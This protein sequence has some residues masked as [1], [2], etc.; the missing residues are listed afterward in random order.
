[1]EDLS[2]YVTVKECDSEALSLAYI[3]YKYDEDDNNVFYLAPQTCTE[4]ITMSKTDETKTKEL[5]VEKI[6]E[7][8]SKVK[9]HEFSMKHVKDISKINIYIRNAKNYIATDGRIGFATNMLVSEDNF[10]KYNLKNVCEELKFDV[11]FDDSVKDVILYRKNNI[12]QPGLV[13]FIHEDKYEFVDIGFYPE[14]Q[15]LKI[16]L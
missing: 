8:A 4:N 12:D 7:L 14:K 11:L 16:I 3:D 2:K 1:M 15:F 9:K 5:L 10:E 13:L 6:V